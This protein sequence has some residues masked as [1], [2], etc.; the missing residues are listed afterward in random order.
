MSTLNEYSIKINK[1]LKTLN[2]VEYKKTYFHIRNKNDYCWYCNRN[3]IN[4]NKFCS[5]IC[6]KIYN[7]N[8][9]FSEENS[10]M[11]S[12]FPFEYLIKESKNKY[13]E[14]LN[15]IDSLNYD[16]VFVM[17]KLIDRDKSF[18][19]I[20]KFKKNYEIIDEQIINIKLIINEVSNLCIYCDGNITDENIYLKNNCF[21]IGYFCSNFC[22]ESF[23]FRNKFL[24]FNINSKFIICGKE[25]FQ[26]FNEI[27][28]KFKNKIEVYTTI[29]NNKI[30]ILYNKDIK[31]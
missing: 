10:E 7:S 29:L 17:Y 31:L 14:F 15:N 18:D 21:F 20:I 13:L 23:I 27:K 24:P 22:L 19:I 1:Y 16:D 6:K 2:K 4:N 5:I 11:M 26:N 9:F 28:K 12:M 8:D 3:T 25:Y 30:N